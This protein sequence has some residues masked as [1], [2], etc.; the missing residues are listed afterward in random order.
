MSTRRHVAFFAVF[1]D[2]ESLSLDFRR[3]PQANRSS[4]ERANENASHDS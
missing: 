1:V 3:N 2:V 4:H